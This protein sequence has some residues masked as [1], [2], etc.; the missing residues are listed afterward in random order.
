MNNNLV[1]EMAQ[2]TVVPVRDAAGARI[3][4]LEGNIWITQENDTTDFV[5]KAGESLALTRNGST[6]VQ[7]MRG[8]R[9]SIQPPHAGGY[10]RLFVRYSP[11]MTRPVPT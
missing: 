6:L 5:L 4:C 9:V 1:L 7:A 10:R 3:A 2:G 11:A 8:S